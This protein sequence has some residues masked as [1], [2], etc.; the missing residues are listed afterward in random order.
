LTQALEID[1]SYDVARETPGGIGLGFNRLGA[2]K[3]ISA[4]RSPRLNPK[5]G[6]HVFDFRGTVRGAYEEIAGNLV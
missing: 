5:P 4:G 1:P 3:G 2:C 6:T